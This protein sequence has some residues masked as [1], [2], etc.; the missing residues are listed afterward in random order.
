MHKSKRE[1]MITGRGTAGKVVVMGTLQR[2]TDKGHSQVMAEVVDNR[3]TQTL[4]DVVKKNVLGSHFSS[5]IGE[6]SKTVP[7]FRENFCRE[8]FS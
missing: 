1:R 4:Q 7:T 6:S 3:H 8:W 5:G 2:N